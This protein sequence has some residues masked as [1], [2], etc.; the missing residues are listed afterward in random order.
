[1]EQLQDN[2]GAVEM[3]LSEEEIK[4]LNDASAWEE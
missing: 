3:E 2:L 4:T 1:L